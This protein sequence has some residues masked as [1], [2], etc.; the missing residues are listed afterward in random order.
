MPHGR[1]GRRF[2]RRRYCLC[3]KSQPAGYRKTDSRRFKILVHPGARATILE[4][5]VNGKDKTSDNFHKIQLADGTVQI[6]SR[7]DGGERV[8]EAKDGTSIDVIEKKL[9]NGYSK[10]W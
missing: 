10:N 8:A 1:V 4:P 3:K 9:G 2:Q 7:A 5:Y 6:M